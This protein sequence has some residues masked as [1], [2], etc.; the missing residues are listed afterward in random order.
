RIAEIRPLPEE[1][2]REGRAYFLSG[3]NTSDDL[4]MFLKKPVS[5]LAPESSYR[6]DFFVE[7]AS[8]AP[9]NC[10]GVGGAPGES[11]WLK[12]GV[13]AVEPV[14]LLEGE[15]GNIIRLN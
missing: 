13:S 6:A 1:V 15:A 11:V 2:G 14:A 12:A 4:F 7:F 10:A 9:S 5:G 8:A 3:R